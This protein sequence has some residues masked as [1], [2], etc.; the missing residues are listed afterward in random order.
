M[1]VTGERGSRH[2]SCLRSSAQAAGLVAKQ[3]TNSNGVSPSLSDR[4]GRLGCW[5][6]QQPLGTALHDAFPGQGGGQV[7]PLGAGTARLV[8]GQAGQEGAGQGRPDQAPA[9]AVGGEAGQAGVAP[10]QIPPGEAAGQQGQGPDVGGAGTPRRLVRTQVTRKLAA[11]MALSQ[12]NAPSQ[13]IDGAAVGM[14]L[15]RSVLAGPSARPRSGA[16]RVRRPGWSRRPAVGSG[17][18][19]R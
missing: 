7:P 3:P 8:A 17:P 16:C 11:A 9:L 14:M 1:G 2:E 10:G 12:P 19:G 18:A 6:Q 5:P 13:E 15:L 4:R